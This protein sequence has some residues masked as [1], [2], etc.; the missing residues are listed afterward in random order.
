MAN[1]KKAKKKALQED[2]TPACTP[3]IFAILLPI[4]ALTLSYLPVL[5]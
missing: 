5:R 3:Y 1:K 2:G 4:Q